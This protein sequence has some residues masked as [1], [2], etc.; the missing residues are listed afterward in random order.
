MQKPE[1][2]WVWLAALTLLAGF[3]AWVLRQKIAVMVD[4]ATTAADKLLWPVPG[5]RNITSPFGMRI[6][7]VTGVHK[8]H[9]GIDIAAPVGADVVAPW[10]AVVTE[11]PTNSTGGTQIILTHT[12][13]VQSGYAHLSERKVAKGDTVKRGQVIGKV[14][15]TGA[16][17]GPHLH[18]TVTDPFGEKLDPRPL[19][20]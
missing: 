8:L 15:K 13:K 10:D 16:V 19:L 2:T 11:T 14:G 18:F 17:T 9:N 4:K 6:H 3:T 1:H 5:Y 20:A 7:P 12:N